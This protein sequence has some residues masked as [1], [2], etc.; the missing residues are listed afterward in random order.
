MLI[1]NGELIEYINSPKYRIVVEDDS[2]E[3]CLARIKTC[4][5]KLKNKINND[6]NII[7]NEGEPK[8]FKDK[9]VSL[10]FICPLS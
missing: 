2:H 7:L 9:E 3:V 8:V 10:K 6:P 4:F 1:N 5:N